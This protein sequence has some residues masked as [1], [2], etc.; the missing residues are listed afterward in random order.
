V[1]NSGTCMDILR[2]TTKNLSQD[3]QSPDRDLNLRPLEY[4]AGVTATWPIGSVT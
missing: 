1:V 2:K 4:E 3:S